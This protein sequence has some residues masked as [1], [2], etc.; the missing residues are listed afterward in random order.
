MRRIEPS[1][2]SCSSVAAR[3]SVLASQGKRDGR[4][5]SITASQSGKTSIGGA[6]SSARVAKTAFYIVGVKPNVA[7]F[8]GSAVIGRTRLATLGRNLR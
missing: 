6:T 1:D 3:P 5:L 2:C 8:L 4:G 7:P